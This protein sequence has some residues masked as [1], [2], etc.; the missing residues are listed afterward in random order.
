M[1]KWFRTDLK[2][3]HADPLKAYLKE[4]DIYFEPSENGDWIHF[5]VLMT[6]KE[7]DQVNGFLDSIFGWIGDY[8][9]G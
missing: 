9:E 1:K 7:A 4:N 3:R 8:N 5:E 2:Q 6:S